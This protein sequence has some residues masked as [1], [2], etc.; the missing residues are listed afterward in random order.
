MGPRTGG[1]NGRYRAVHRIDFSGLRRPGRYLIVV[2][3]LAAP[4]PAFRVASRRALFRGLVADTV[5]FFQV[6]RDGAHVP[7]QLDRSPPT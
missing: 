4:S 6:Q 3:G 1:W 2:D 7:R 5:R